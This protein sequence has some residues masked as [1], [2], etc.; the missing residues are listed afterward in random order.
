MDI[1]LL[2]KMIKEL[3]LEKDEVALPGIGTF[4]TEIVPAS[5]SDKGYTI[6]PPYRRLYFRQ[7][8]NNTDTALFDFYAS[9]NNIDDNNARRIVMDFLTEMKSVLED[10]KTIVFPGLGRLRA[11]KEN[12]FFFVAD[13]DLDIW[14]EGFGLE[15]VSLKTHQET[16]EEVS[17]AVAGL[18]DIMDMPAE[19]VSEPVDVLSAI[20]PETLQTGSIVSP[21]DISQLDPIAVE[22]EAPAI[23]V[24]SDPKE[25]YVEPVANP[26][27]EDYIEPVADPKKE[28]YVEPSADPKK[29]DY[30]EPEV[31]LKKETYSEPASEAASQPIPEVPAAQNGGHFEEP[32]LRVKEEPVVPVTPV[33]PQKPV[34]PEKP[35]EEA[36]PVE[37]EKPIEDPKPAEEAKPAES[38]E[39]LKPTEPEQPI[40][41]AKPAEQAEAA[42]PATEETPIEITSKDQPSKLKVLQWIGI[43]ILIAIAVAILAFIIIGHVAPQLIDPLLYSPDELDVINYGK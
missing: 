25:E 19:E 13:E 14:P 20:V 9:S 5:F 28:E 7:R 26:K 24:V 10:K 18:K 12:N 2:S 21:V 37:P 4:A 41:E 23:D 22:D 39:E 8:Q 36:K 35:V 33:E 29:E 1:D 43:G 16:P 30:V 34:E 3:I 27:K 31:A 40:E 17:A 38:V 11:T 32:E 6:H 42:K 15:P